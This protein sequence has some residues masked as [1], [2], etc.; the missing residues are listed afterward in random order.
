VDRRGS[1]Y[2]WP[3]EDVQRNESA[4]EIPCRRRRGGEGLTAAPAR[5]G[6]GPDSSSQGAPGKKLDPNAP[7][8]EAPGA[9]GDL[10]CRLSRQW[11]AGKVVENPHR[12]TG[13][14]RKNPTKGKTP[15]CRG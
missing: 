13:T 2:A 9:K 15:A 12:E 11:A 14:G 1:V 4:L 5:D 6:V 8:R 10:K 3:Q 7:P